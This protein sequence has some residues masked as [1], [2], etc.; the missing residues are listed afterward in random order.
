MALPLQKRKDKFRLNLSNV[1]YQPNSVE[2]LLQDFRPLA[3]K[4]KSQN[5]NYTNI[6]FINSDL[7]SIL[8][9]SNYLLS[10]NR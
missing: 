10:L 4:S 6:E 1:L 5:K 9:F 3:K 2:K 8:E 7:K